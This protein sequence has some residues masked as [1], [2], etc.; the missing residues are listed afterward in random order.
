VSDPGERTAPRFLGLG[1]AA[2]LLGCQPLNAPQLPGVPGVGA[3]PCTTASAAK[4]AT[5]AVV[6]GIC[7]PACIEVP[8]GTAVTF[9]NQDPVEYQFAA[10]AA[11]GFG[12]VVV[13]PSSAART[14]PLSPGTVDASALEDPAA[15]VTILVD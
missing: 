11:P 7:N 12:V 8:D 10:P 1:L 13:P 4:V 9:L 3:T 6:N 2:A 15:A 14:P 5:V